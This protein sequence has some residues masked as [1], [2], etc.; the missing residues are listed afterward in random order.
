[1]KLSVD[2][3]KADIVAMVAMAAA[4]HPDWMTVLRGDRRLYDPIL[5]SLR[6]DARRRRSG[7]LATAS[8]MSQTG[9][10]DTTSSE[11]LDRVGFEIRHDQRSDVQNVWIELQRLQVRFD[12]FARAVVD[13]MSRSDAPIQGPANLRDALPT[14]L[15]SELLYPNMAAAFGL[16]NTGWAGHVVTAEAP[17]IPALR[18][19]DRAE[20]SLVRYTD[21]ESLRAVLTAPLDELSG[22]IPQEIALPKLKQHVRNKRLATRGVDVRDVHRISTSFWA[23][24]R[25]R[26]PPDLAREARMFLGSVEGI[27]SEVAFPADSVRAAAARGDPLAKE[28]IELSNRRGPMGRERRRPTDLRTAWSKPFDNGSRYVIEDGRI[29]VEV[30]Q[31]KDE[32]IP[33]Q[34]IFMI[35]GDG[36]VPALLT[37]RLFKVWAGATMQSSPSWS[38]RFRLGLTFETFP[39]PSEFIV[40]QS[41]TDA[42]AQLRVSPNPGRLRK[43]APMFRENS[44]ELTQIVDARNR[45][46]VAWE[47][48]PLMKQIEVALLSTIGLES[49]ATDLDILERLVER[50][51]R[52]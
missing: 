1:M 20:W 6:M 49:N 39:I 4:I 43:F 26:F 8:E 36:S 2:R 38:S 21:A 40:F 15:I 3:R 27:A 52:D 28:V 48:H 35:D 44:N 45:R 9:L 12:I 47:G 30:T 50:N 11:I 23:E 46:D 7:V 31:L 34:H 41:D 33:A 13:E 17:T 51:K 16:P 37:S 29:P 14:T 18:A 5:L 22:R 24:S 42:P 19:A 10:S 32:E 25:N